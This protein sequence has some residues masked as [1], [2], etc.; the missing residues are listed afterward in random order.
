M[1]ELEDLM[2]DCWL[3]VSLHPED[4]ITGQLD[5]GFPWF[6]L[7]PEQMLSTQIPRSTACSHAALPIVTLKILLINQ[8]DFDFDFGLYHLFMGDMGEG[9][10][11]EERK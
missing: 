6:S 11:H 1:L 10:L 9:S 8:H 5:K 3:E 2:P 7:V 4:P